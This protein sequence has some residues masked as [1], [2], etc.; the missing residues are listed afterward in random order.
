M[1]PQI[2]KTVKLTEPILAICILIILFD[3]REIN[4]GNNIYFEHFFQRNS[5]KILFC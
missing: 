3:D 1:C 4:I 5:E 2:L